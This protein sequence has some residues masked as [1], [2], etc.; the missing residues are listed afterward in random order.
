MDNPLTSE[1][2]RVCSR[3]YGEYDISFFRSEGQRA[4]SAVAASN[5]RAI[6]VGCELTARTEAKVH[7]RPFEKAKRT[8]ESHAVKYVK[9]GLAAN[10]GDF[11]RR[12]RWDAKR[13]AYEI[14]HAH[15][16]TCA[17]CWQPYAEME[18]GLADVTLDIVNPQ[19]P[20]WY[21]LNTQWCCQ[22]CNREKQRLSPEDWTKRR[23]CWDAWHSNQTSP[24]HPRLFDV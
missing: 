14:Q 5:R 8:I 13:M 17:Y 19:E 18:H 23:I 6:C 24:V 11:V 22:T 2:T 12:Y 4:A 3:C 1:Q 10:K 9:Q 7:D 15:E 20:P 16:N 21:G